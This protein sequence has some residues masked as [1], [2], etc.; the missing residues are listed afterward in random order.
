MTHESPIET[1]I[2]WHVIETP[3]ASDDDRVA[4]VRS[5]ASVLITSERRDERSDCARSIHFE[6]V[7]R[8][9]PFV[10]FDCGVS[11]VVRAQ[12]PPT[13]RDDLADDIRHRYCAAAAGTLFLDRIETMNGGIQAI[14]MSLL[15]ETVRH[16][17]RTGP[18]RR[19]HPRLIAGAS[20][21]L[22]TAV[23][24]GRFNTALFYRL[25]VIQLD[26]RHI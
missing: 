14:L 24:G 26:L 10:V 8:T 22:R 11:D 6:G 21:S 4:A 3:A 15:D 2:A 9:G 1:D 23:S 12:H 17:D 20:G 7:R 16:R 18:A 5:T 25:N 19:S 13:G